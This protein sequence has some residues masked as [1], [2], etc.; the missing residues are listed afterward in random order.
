MRSLIEY[1]V[2]SVA[3]N[4]VLHRTVSG[5]S[6][7]AIKLLLD[8]GAD[9]NAF[10]AGN[11]ITMAAQKALAS[12]CGKGSLPIIRLLL[13]RGAD[14]NIG[15]VATSIRAALYRMS[16]SIEVLKLLLEHGADPNLPFIDGSTALLEVLQLVHYCNQRLIHTDSLQAFTLL[17]Q[18]GADPNLA[19]ARTGETPLMV[20]AKACLTD[21]VRLLLEHGADVTQVDLTGKSVLDMMGRTRRYD[22]MVKLCTQ[23]VDSNKPGAKHVLK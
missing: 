18:Y 8:S 4:E 23:Y 5:D 13:E 15:H 14:P 21:Y 19:K 11:F 6:I 17:L 7:E 2:D 22:E 12:A 16:D 1:G 9:S 3:L 10:K 20:A